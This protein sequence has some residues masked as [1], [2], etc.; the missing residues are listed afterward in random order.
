MPA[1]LLDSLRRTPHAAP[2]LA[3]L[4]GEPGVHLVGGAVRDVLLGREPRELDVVVEGDLPGVARRAARRLG[5]HAVVRE[6]FGTATVRTAAVV[7]DLAAT[8]RERY[9]HPGALPEVEVGATL[10]EDLERRDFT[11]NAIAVALA[12]GVVT[13]H[14]R[15]LADIADRSLRVLH[16]ASFSDDPTRMLRMCRYAA[17]LALTPEAG[18]ALLAAAAVQRGALRTV[19]G[20]RLGRE[21]RMLAREPQPAA[22]CHLERFGIG[23]AVVHP[24]FLV[25]GRLVRTVLDLCPAEARGDLVALAS[26]L[27]AVP[28]ADVARRLGELGFPAAERQVVL[29]VHGRAR[30]VSDVLGRVPD[31]DGAAL[32]EL[33]G[34]ESL[35]TV[36]MAGALAGEVGAANARRWL[37]ELRHVEVLITGHDLTDE[38]LT[39]PAVGRGLRAA[40]AAALSGR[41]PD[42][43]RQLAAALTAARAP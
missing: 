35:E 23:T 43:E 21:L 20:E 15:A 27:L 9:P 26:T 42:R 5:G 8:R 13:A 22:L 31:A 38:G 6:R 10:E 12:G 28:S 25:D 29:S 19:S 2:V 3:A 1:G 32:G 4:A 33:L 16:P 34:A 24:G 39:G 40:R 41:A 11:V 30:P 17:R 37:T 14:P 18:T 36:A 7:F